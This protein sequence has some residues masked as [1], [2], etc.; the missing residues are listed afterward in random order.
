MSKWLRSTTEKAWT[1]E[2]NNKQRL[3]PGNQGSWLE[4]DD[5][6]YITLQ[7]RPAIKSLLDTKGIYVTEQRP[8]ELS[9]DLPTLKNERA[10]LTSQV[11]TLTG[12]VQDLQQQL[13]QAEEVKQ[14]ELHALDDK[15]SEI[16]ADK[17]QAL[18]EKDEEI[19]KLKK[20]LKTLEKAN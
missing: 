2:I 1:V 6:E 5:S 12:Q 18:R 17:D 10:E 15:A 20:Q 16:I 9:D 13:A 4:L 3:I 8:S 11:Q 19:K 14:Q 7:N